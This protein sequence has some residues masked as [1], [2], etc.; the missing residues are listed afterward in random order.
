MKVNCRLNSD[1]L[2]TT[3]FGSFQTARSNKVLSLSLSLLV[4]IDDI[5]W[6]YL[7][8]LITKYL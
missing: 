2:E 7:K 6:N 3:L 8:I 5:E 4:C 1:V